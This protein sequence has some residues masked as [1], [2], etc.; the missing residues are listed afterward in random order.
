MKERPILFSAPMVRAIIEGRKTQTRRLI[1]PQ[2]DLI[3]GDLLG[4]PKWY[5][6]AEP[7]RVVRC[8]YGVPGDLL[9]VRETCRP[10]NDGS[11]TYRADWTEDEI[12]T[13]AR[14]TCPRATQ[15]VVM[16]WIPAI[17]MRREDSRIDLEI[18]KV[19]AERLHDIT[20][21]DARAEGVSLSA[22]EPPDED[23]RVVGYPDPGGSFARDNFMRLW[24]QINGKRAP[25]VSNS[26]VW[27]M[28]F[29][30]LR[31]GK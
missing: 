26:W 11:V 9:W 8:P 24:D 3:V 27:A 2:A 4:Q 20:D 13:G 16:R 5:L 6:D 28:E 23:P 25:W 12:K 17:H 30:L 14:W 29:R 21:E 22:P 7:A 10:R 18:V 1:K 31:G 15:G 19:R